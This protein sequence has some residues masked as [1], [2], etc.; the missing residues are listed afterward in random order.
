VAVKDS[1]DLRGIPTTAGCPA[2]AR[3]PDRSAPAVEHLQAHGA[4]VVGKTNLDQFATGLVGTR[5]PYGVVR[6]ALDP[7]RVSGGSSSGSAVA[8]A[9]GL[10]DLALGT[11]T[12][13]SGRVPAAFNAIVGIKPTRGLVSN[14]GVVPACP[15]FDCV[16]VFAR[17]LSLG[18]LALEAMARYVDDDPTSR[19][20]PNRVPS[21][22][23]VVGVPA[24]GELGLDPP[25]AA[26]FTAAVDRLG[27]LVEV[28]PIDLALFDEAGALLYGGGFVAERYAAVGEFVDDHPLEVDPTVAAIIGAARDIPAHRLAADIHRLRALRRAAE[29]VFSSVDAVLVPTAPRLPTIEAVQADPIALN[30]GL[31]RFTSPVNLLDLCAL[32]IPAGTTADGLPFGVSLHAAA[33]RDEDLLDLAAR[34]DGVDATGSGAGD[35]Q[36]GSDARSAGVDPPSTADGTAHGV[37]TPGADDLDL[38]VAGAHLLGQPLNHQLTDRGGRLIETTTTSAR[39]ALLALDTDPPKPGLVWQPDGGGTIEVE[40]WRLPATGFASFIA[41]VPPPMAIGAVELADGSWCTGFTCMPH[42][43]VAAADITASGG[44]RAHLGQVAPPAR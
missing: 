22:I 33:F 19:V 6:N 36:R 27:A 10:V 18:R 9:L 25:T 21:P 24:I 1:I 4:V 41:Q 38:I 14:R 13:G 32:A 28:V 8:V 2:F 11:D 39:Y 44:W 37:R 20:A 42:A 35:G 17:D 7:T 30:A 26:A 34:L 40:R 29:L 15:S 23:T 43:V 3:T 5:S 31:G 12:A 16:S